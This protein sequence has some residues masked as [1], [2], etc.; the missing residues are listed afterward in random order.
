MARSRLRSRSDEFVNKHSLLQSSPGDGS[1]DHY[2]YFLPNSAYS[3]GVLTCFLLLPWHQCC[4]TP[5]KLTICQG[6]AVRLDQGKW[7]RLPQGQ[8]GELPVRRLFFCRRPAAMPR[9]SP[10]RCRVFLFGAIFQPWVG[11]CCKEP[12]KLARLWRVGGWEVRGCQEARVRIRRVDDDC[13]Q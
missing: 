12:G 13:L 5:S 4:K 10:L 2:N 3:H 11:G 7:P 9:L 8:R 1:P 6:A